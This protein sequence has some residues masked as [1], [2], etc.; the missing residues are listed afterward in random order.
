VTVDV[1]GTSV[2][3][4]WVVVDVVPGAALVDVEPADV[5]DVVVDELGVGLLE[6]AASAKAQAGRS[7]RLIDRIRKAEGTLQLMTAARSNGGSVRSG[8]RQEGR[9]CLISDAPGSRPDH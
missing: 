1:C 4:V 5:V 6:Q 7:N 8:M 9:R 3:D 2:P